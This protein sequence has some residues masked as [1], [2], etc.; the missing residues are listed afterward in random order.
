MTAV[1]AYFGVDVLG[2]LTTLQLLAPLDAESRLR[3]LILAVGRVLGAV[4]GTAPL[5]LPLLAFGWKK[6]VGGP[7]IVRPILGSHQVIN[8]LISVTAPFLLSMRILLLSG[9]F[10]DAVLGAFLDAVPMAEQ[11]LVRL[12][13]AE[14]KAHLGGSF[15]N[16]GGVRDWIYT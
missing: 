14:V 8:I 1:H 3:R 10:A 15:G 9:L 11:F 16:V 13:L 4:Q 2:E 7:I 6:L 12:R 5:V